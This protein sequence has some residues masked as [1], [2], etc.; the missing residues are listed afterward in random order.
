MLV[1]ELLEL[2]VDVVDADLLET[3]VVEDLK[4]GNIEH[5]NVGDLLHGGV[6]QGLVTLVDDNP[7][8][9]LVDGTG[10]TGNG[11]GSVGASGALVHPLG[12]DLQLGLAEVG[13]HPFLVDGQQV[14]NLLSVG[15][16]LDLGLLLLANWDKVLGHVAHVHHAGGVLE[17]V[18][19]LLLIMIMSARMPTE[20]LLWC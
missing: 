8:G 4:A 16:V 20:N 6:A 14:G 12:S 18:V 17:N 2:L 11:V 5:T 13:D 7:E 1:E 19:L 3:V 10:D 15:L 9:T